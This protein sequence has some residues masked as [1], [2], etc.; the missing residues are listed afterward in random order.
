MSL[1]DSVFG[2]GQ[3]SKFTICL[4]FCYPHVIACNYNTFIPNRVAFH[5]E[6]T[7]S[8]IRGMRTPRKGSMVTEVTALR[9][10]SLP[11]QALYSGNFIAL[12]MF[13][14]R[15]FGNCHERLPAP[16]LKIGLPL[17]KTP[18]TFSRQYPDGL[19]S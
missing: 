4:A 5:N 13:S 7:P 3:G 6:C 19:P 10:E 15:Y 11:R 9:R 17:R 18:D 16:Y 1:I 2:E 8:P 14:H 12:V